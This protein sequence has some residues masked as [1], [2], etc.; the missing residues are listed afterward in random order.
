[1][2]DRKEI[3]HTPLVYCQSEE[4][5]AHKGLMSEAGWSKKKKIEYIHPLGQ[6]ILAFTEF[7]T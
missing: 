7:S 6:N 3:Q 4:R 5:G 2:F 1:M